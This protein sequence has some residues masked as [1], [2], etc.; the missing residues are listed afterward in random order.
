[1]CNKE[2]NLIRELV[3]ALDL[4]ELTDGYRRRLQIIDSQVE[5]LNRLQDAYREGL[6]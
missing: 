4:E 3:K 5:A 1:M 2:E 6:I